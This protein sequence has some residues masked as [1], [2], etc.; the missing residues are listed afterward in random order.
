[1]SWHDLIDV[2]APEILDH[3]KTTS[4]RLR[5][6]GIPHAVCGGIAVGVLGYPRATQRVD[7]LIGRG[8]EDPSDSNGLSREVAALYRKGVIDFVLVRRRE[9]EQGL[10]L[11]ALRRQRAATDVIPV[12]GPLELVWLKL[13]TPEHRRQHDLNDIRQ[14]LR[15]GAI[16]VDEV[17]GWL[18]LHDRD[19]A[20]DFAELAQEV[21]AG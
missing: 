10:L 7:F 1:L 9:P 20:E 16:D 17:L 8:G 13:S 5:E 3:A 11:D 14:L 4:D 2:V 6:L 21:L 18:E 12:V 19:K 15:A